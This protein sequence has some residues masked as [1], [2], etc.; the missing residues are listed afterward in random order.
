[1]LFSSAVFLFLF[2]PIILLLLWKDVLNKV[3]YYG[4]A[5]PHAIGSVIDI[6]EICTAIDQLRIYFIEKTLFQLEASI[7]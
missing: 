2:L 4:S 6:F 7:Q 3:G 5:P 1:M